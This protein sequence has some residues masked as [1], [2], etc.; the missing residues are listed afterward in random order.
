MH[1]RSLL[2]DQLLANANDRS[3]YISYQE[4]VEG[5]TD[6]EAFWKPNEQTHSIAEITQHLIYWNEVWQERYEKADL[7][8]IETVEDNAESFFVT[9]GNDFEKLK[10]K[11]LGV[12]LSWQ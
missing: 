3:W 5:L 12:L 8:V 7:H 2:K 4:V 10:E 1:V 9:N 6:D 11:L